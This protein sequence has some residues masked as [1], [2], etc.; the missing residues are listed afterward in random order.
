VANVQVAILGGVTRLS[1]APTLVAQGRGYFAEQGLEVE[2][3]GAH[4]DHAMEM[5][6]KGEIDVAAMRPGLY[7]YREWNPERPAAMVADGGRLLPGK[8]GG[9][10]VARPA[11]VA[12]GTLR[13]Y[14]DLRGL[15]IGLSPDKGDHDWLTIAAA[16][17]KAGLSWDDVDVIECDYGD[18][19]H[20]ALTKGTIDVTTVSNAKSVAE[21]QKAGAFVPWKFENDVEE[22]RQAASVIYSK[23]FRDD[24]D[25]AQRYLTA[26]LRG[27]RDYYRAFHESEE[28]E[29]AID[30]LASVSGLTAEAVAR[31][32]IPLAIDPDGRLNMKSLNEDLD[33]MHA[34]GVIPPSVTADRLV[35]YSYLDRALVSLGHYTG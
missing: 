14:Q 24:A 23:A 29:A 30:A 9:A 7:F 25:R 2:F 12:D 31:D 15:R 19:R 6:C 35:D 21:G 1:G 32:I 28:R 4:G 34:Q 16:L 22:G 33:W 18:G 8:G 5:V 10:I 13:E 3:V 11:L 17:R 20:E 26:Y 27:A